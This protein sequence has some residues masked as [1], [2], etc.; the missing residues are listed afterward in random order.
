VVVA[1]HTRM[2]MALEQHDARACMW[3]LAAYI[4]YRVFMTTQKS[5]LHMCDHVLLV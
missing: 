3:M 4:W 2:Q 5:G 1:S